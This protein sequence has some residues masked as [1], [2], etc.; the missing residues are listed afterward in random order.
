MFMK[1]LMLAFSILITFSVSAQTVQDGDSIIRGDGVRV[2]LY[3]IDAP[4]KDQPYARK[5]L[6]QYMPLVANMKQYDEDRYGRLIVE[7]FTED[8]KS[9]NAAMICSGA[10][11]WYEYYAP[12]RPQFKQ[13]QEDAQKAK[14]G[15]WAD[16]DPIPPWSWRRR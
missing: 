14:R 3:G 1:S 13:C 9:I 4:E 8:N 7:L 12:D 6:K 10:A 15:L 11:W 16:E 2:R 5:V